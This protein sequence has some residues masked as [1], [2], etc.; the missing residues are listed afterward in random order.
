MLS[1][2]LKESILQRRSIRKY[3]NKQ[4]KIE[5]LGEILDIARFSPSSGN[6][7]NWHFIIVTDEKKKEEIANACLEQMWMTEAPVY[8]VICNKF[9]KVTDMFGKLGKMYSIQNCSIIASNIMLLAKD[10]GLDTCW[11]GGFSNESIQRIL[12]IPEDVDP[13]IIL[14]LG[15][16]NEEKISEP[17]REELNT[18]VYFEKWGKKQAKFK[19]S[20]IISK[21]KKILK[22]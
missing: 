12:S 3:K 11:V 4:V 16:S 6:L 14:A 18:M 7:Q 20:G 13:E 5:T 2:E 9:K 15:Y 19:S 17:I 8:I 22:K 10:Y 21:L 1:M